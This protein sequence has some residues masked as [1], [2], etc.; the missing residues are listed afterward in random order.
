MG[1][2][3]EKTETRELKE[4]LHRLIAQNKK[5]EAGILLEKQLKVRPD[6]LLP[7][8]DINHELRDIYD[9]LL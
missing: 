1:V 9:L 5:K 2:S 7:A 4:A 3:A 6:L 8:S